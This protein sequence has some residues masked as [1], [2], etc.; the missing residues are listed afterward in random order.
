VDLTKIANI[1]CG[2]D[3]N[4]AKRT[5]RTALA[6]RGT[7]HGDD[8]PGMDLTAVVDIS[9]GESVCVNLILMIAFFLRTCC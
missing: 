4:V 8:A 1:G 5:N 2:W 7:D 9:C 3:V 6:L